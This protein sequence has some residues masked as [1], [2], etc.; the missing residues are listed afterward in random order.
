MDTETEFNNILEKLETIDL[1]TFG[2]TDTIKLEFY[3]YYKQSKIGDCN[4]N[5]PSFIYFKDCAKWDAWNSIK[6]MSKND[7]MKKYIECYN[8]YIL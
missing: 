8:I 4:T 2:L 5:R 3:K 7:A 1:D 6:N